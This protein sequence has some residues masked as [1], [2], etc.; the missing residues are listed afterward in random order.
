MAR[1]LW[2]KRVK[3]NPPPGVVF[4]P[5]MML[6]EPIWTD[7]PPPRIGPGVRAAVDCVPALNPG[8]LQDAEGNWL[9]C[10]NCDY[11]SDDGNVT[12]KAGVLID[13]SKRTCKYEAGLLVIGRTSP[14]AHVLRHEGSRIKRHKGLRADGSEAK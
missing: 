3:N 4:C 2:L 7:G 12:D 6:L 5:G 1:T 13:F 10:G 9:C 14:G 8:A 11:V